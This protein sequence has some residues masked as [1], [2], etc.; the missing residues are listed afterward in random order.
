MSPVENEVMLSL[1]QAENKL[2]PLLDSLNLFSYLPAPEKFC[3]GLQARHHKFSQ[4]L[5]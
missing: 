4:V 3:S 2:L 1:K 5:K